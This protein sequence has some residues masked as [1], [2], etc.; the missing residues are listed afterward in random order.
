MNSHGIIFVRKRLST[1]TE[2]LCVYRIDA[3]L[4]IEIACVSVPYGL[5][6]ETLTPHWLYG[7]LLGAVLIAVSTS[8]QQWIDNTVRQ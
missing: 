5:A 3:R 4:I 6:S 7:T 8:R 1:F 2:S